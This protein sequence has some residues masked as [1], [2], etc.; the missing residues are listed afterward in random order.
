MS[1]ETES[2]KD[3][4]ES[5]F[6]SNGG[7]SQTFEDGR[8]VHR[9]PPSYGMTL[10]DYFA[11]MAMGGLIESYESEAREKTANRAARTGF[12]ENHY[13]SDATYATQ[14]AEE[15]YAIADAMLVARGRSK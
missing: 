4:P 12:D 8:T 1:A 14:M 7:D 11:A 6:P 5:A 10:R 3:W 2:Q 15:S 13:D 9:F